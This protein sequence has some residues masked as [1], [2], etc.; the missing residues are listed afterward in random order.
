MPSRHAPPRQKNLGVTGL[1][2][3]SLLLGFLGQLC[4]AF[5]ISVI[6]GLVC[7][8]A[9]SYS[10]IRTLS[11]YGGDANAIFADSSS[12]PGKLGLLTS[13]KTFEWLLVLALL[14]VAAFFR[15]Y[16]IDSQPSSL[17]LDESLTGLNALEIIEGRD[18]P[19]WQMTPL[20]RWRPAW[21]KTS[22]LYLYYVVMIFKVFGTEY[23]GLKMVSVLPAIAA[24]IA[25][26]F[27]FREMS[28]ITT[29]FLAAFLTAVSQWHVTI[30]RWGWDALLMCFLQ[31]ICYWLLL[32]GLKKGR[33]S[34]LVLSG[35]VMGLCLYTYIASWLA[36]AIA[37]SFLIFRSASERPVL[38]K[39][40]Q[41]ALFFLVPCL[42][43]FVPLGSYYV[44][45][46][47]DLFT[48][49]A[50]LNIGKSVEAAQSFLPVWEGISKYALMFNAKGDSN[51]R[52][53]FP[54]E[55]LLDFVTAVFF[56]L[57][58]VCCL[59]FWK[60]IHVAF[61]LIWFALGLQAGL[62]SEPSEAPNAYRT[63]M[64]APAAFFFAATSMHLCFSILRRSLESSRFAVTPFVLAVTLIGY[65]IAINYWTYFVKRPKS[66]EVWEEESRDG[67]LPAKLLSLRGDSRVVI[68]DP[69]LLWKVVVVNGWFLSYHPGKLFEPLFSGKNL[70]AAEKDLDSLGGEQ[71]LTYVFSPVFARMI[72]SLFPE[73]VSPVVQSP[74]GTP[75]YGVVTTTVADLRLRL[76]STDQ[77]SL[78][79][80]V[81]KTAA[82]Y[83]Q[84]ARTDGEAGPRRKLLVEE[85][86]AGIKL[87]KQLTSELS[88]E[89]KP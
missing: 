15:L 4:F 58:L 53:G 31:L 13:K 79:A 82:F 85:S 55:P 28:N 7:Y 50:E 5:D 74:F 47:N 41:D 60:N 30:S 23:L 21:V 75:L 86:E 87:A 62:L 59:R 73:A 64:I 45:H 80:A 18:A 81:Y 10:F 43:V 32:A 37:I 44:S 83:E 56:V 36:L 77:R 70:F 51:P 46:P 38:G 63:L 52:H 33:R 89:Q 71:L 17:W 61:V 29:A 27:L 54:G 19:I 78:A 2:A 11:Q 9:A 40:I 67:G 14:A 84:Q 66:R 48:R 12:L 35:G 1:L 68:V 76:A 34:H 24:V 8:A 39:R 6:A 26:Y 88:S 49:T 42:L 57:G 20:D 22:N 69:L 3:V 72:Q 25:V 65:S 16:R